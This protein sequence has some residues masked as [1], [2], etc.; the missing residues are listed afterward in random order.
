MTRCTH[1]PSR[2]LWKGVL[3]P[4]TAYAGDAFADGLM[5]L[6]GHLG[7]CGGLIE[8][9]LRRATHVIDG[10][11]TLD[12]GA[13]AR[14]HDQLTILSASCKREVIKLAWHAPTRSHLPSLVIAFRDAVDLQRMGNTV[15]EISA[16][17]GTVAAHGRPHAHMLGQVNGAAIR[18]AASLK[19]LL[20]D[21]DRSRATQLCDDG[22]A[23]HEM[24]TD[25]ERQTTAWQ[26]GD[27]LELLDLYGRFVDDAMVIAYRAHRRRHRYLNTGPNS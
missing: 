18:L 3:M 9:A 6:R 25:L 8:L 16:R 13:I 2:R 19:R 12:P 23:V 10:D 27:I 24:L 14:D 5:A 1:P 7:H 11:R 22:H 4:S 15:G 20:P 17:C 21:G 26:D